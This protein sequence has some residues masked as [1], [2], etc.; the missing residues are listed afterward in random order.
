MEFIVNH[1]VLKTKILSALSSSVIVKN[2]MVPDTHIS[3]N[4]QVHIGLC[5]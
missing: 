3:I 1:Q 4:H 2:E 5:M